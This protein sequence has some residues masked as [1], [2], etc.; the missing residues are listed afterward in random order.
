[1][2]DVANIAE[3]NKEQDA[4]DIRAIAER[5]AGLLRCSCG[6]YKP[7]GYS[8]PHCGDVY[9]THYVKCRNVDCINSCEIGEGGGRIS[10]Y[11]VHCNNEAAEQ[12]R[13]AD[14][15]QKEAEQRKM[16][17]EHFHYIDI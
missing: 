9:G 6:R 10:E 8:C 15:K 16:I 11:C 3:V 4:R 14:A 1:M 5:F 7:R 17:E 2:S 13:L 12:K